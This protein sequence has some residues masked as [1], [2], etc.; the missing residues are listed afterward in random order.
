MRPLKL[1]D[2]LLHSISR[3]DP[4]KYCS[5]SQILFG[6]YEAEVLD[7]VDISQCESGVFFSD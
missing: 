2:F 5:G 3:T 4:G 7:E 1:T 6:Q